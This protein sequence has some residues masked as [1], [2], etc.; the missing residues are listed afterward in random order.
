M[1]MKL[2][3]V[4]ITEMQFLKVFVGL[5]ILDNY[6]N[7]LTDFGKTFLEMMLQGVISSTFILEE[8][9]NIFL[10]TSVRAL[11]GARKLMPN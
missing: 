1:H 5:F 2:Y 8:E 4:L 3:A 7:G 6:R 9:S 10:L 11:E